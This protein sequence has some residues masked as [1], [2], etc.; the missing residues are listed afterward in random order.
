MGMY[1][2]LANGDIPADPR[3]FTPELVRGWADRG[4]RC[5]AFGFPLPH[6]EVA[7]AAGE[8]RPLLEDHGIH[9]S[10]YVGINAHL[11]ATDPERRADGV[12]RIRSAIPA[13]KALDATMMQSG[14]GTNAIGATGAGNQHHHYTPHPDNYSRAARDGLVAA[15]REVARIVEDEGMV[16][17]MECHQLTTM[18]SAEVI[19]DVLDEVDSP[20]VVANFDPV[21]LLDSAVAVY[22][23]AARMRAM[24]EV[25]L[26]ESGVPRYGPSCHVKDVVLGS[27]LTCHIDEAP[28]GHGVLDLAT[29][30]DVAQLLPAGR[31]GGA[32]LI[33]EHLGAGASYAGI[34]LVR[35]AALAHGV[36]LL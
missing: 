8:L 23:N 4:I 27:D 18:R 24:G 13:A 3:R 10:Q 19:R 22:D 12:A 32:S 30:F 21:N 5:L 6:D 17:S 29:L 16:F 31:R 20:A 36:E 35:E 33:V 28:P 26:P 9:V 15:L 11:S 25:L 1:L 2:G 14:V 7:A 34:D